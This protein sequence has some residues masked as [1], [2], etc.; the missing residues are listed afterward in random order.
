MEIKKLQTLGPDTEG[1]IEDLVDK[2]ILV[3]EDIQGTKIFVRWDG[4]RWR[5]K[6]RSLKSPDLNHYDIMIQNYWAP[7]VNYFQNLPVE[8]RSLI[9]TNYWYC[10]EYFY[11]TQPAHIQYDQKPKNGL[12]LTWI[13][14]LG[15]IWS[16]NVSELWEFSQLLKTDM[17]PVIFFGKLSKDQLDLLKTYVKTSPDDLKYCFDEISFA[18]FFYKIL[19]KDSENS[20]GMVSGRWN[21]NLEKLIIR[22][23]DSF[24]QFSLELL[25]PLYKETKRDAT[26]YL[27]MHSMIIMNFLEFYH[28]Q[29]LSKYKLK[30]GTLE[31][32]Y[33][34]LISNLFLDYLEKYTQNSTNWVFT[35]PPFY[36]EQKFRLN[37]E[38]IQS[39]DL[40][41][42]IAVDTK[43]EYCFKIILNSF[44]KKIN[45]PYGVFNDET[46]ETHN[47]VVLNIWKFLEKL[48]NI[49]PVH[50]IAPIPISGEFPSLK[51]DGSGNLWLNNG[52]LVQ[53]ETP[54]K[55]DKPNN[56]NPIG[57]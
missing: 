1:L 10:F 11:D 16:Q 33:C 19:D 8:I 15:K 30:P 45:K 37:L 39:E 22:N 17:L 41:K 5:F 13:V 51:T 25:N 52:K 4:I 47:A 44:Y 20:F 48:Q 31:E 50:Q 49:T 38:K 21:G 7:L 18:K 35:L 9:H 28:L 29:D 2:K 43:K 23:V 12:V 26:H 57:L 36:S 46:K 14:K 24:S 27:T 34:E 32:N 40:K 55:K 56:M 53:K 54:S 6:A 42:A 3:Y